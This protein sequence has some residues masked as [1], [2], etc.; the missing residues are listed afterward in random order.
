MSAIGTKTIRASLVTILIMF[1]ANAALGL[2]SDLN[3]YMSPSEVQFQ[4]I[5]PAGN[6]TGYDPATGKIVNNIPNTHYFMDQEPT[7]PVEPTKYQKFMVIQP[8]LISDTTTVA[9]GIY[10]IKVFGSV[11]PEDFHF[12]MQLYYHGYM[13]PQVFGEASGTVTPNTTLTYQMTVPAVPPPGGQMPITMIASSSS[14]PAL[15]PAQTPPASGGAG[16]QNP[17]AKVVTP[18]DLIAEITAAGQSGQIGNAEFVN[19]LIKK[20]NALEKEQTESQEHPN[21]V[22]SA[23]KAI[24]KYQKFLKEITERYQKPE[25][26][27]FVKQEAYAVLKEDLDYIISHIK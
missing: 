4:V 10:T 21:E 2:P 17:P 26:D 9:T 14:V 22:S 27:E 18:A 23:Q 15:P 25:K 3:A 8:T 11:M 12:T 20:V 1:W 5:D 19:E 16:V 24:K 6:V 7:G 13:G